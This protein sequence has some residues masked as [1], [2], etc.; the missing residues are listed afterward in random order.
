MRQ[1]R[2][3]AAAAVLAATAFAAATPADAAP[4]RVLRYADTGYCQVWD[5]GIGNRPWTAYTKMTRRHWSFERTLAIK[6]W[7]LRHHYCN[8]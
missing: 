6:G 4:Y 2:V 3:L 5:Y 7:L 8:W 1:L